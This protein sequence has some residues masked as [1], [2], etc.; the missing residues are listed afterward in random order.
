MTSFYQLQVIETTMPF[1]QLMTPYY[2]D[3]HAAKVGPTSMA[4]GYF[5]IDPSTGAK[6][7]RALRIPLIPPNVLK[8]T[9]S[10]TVTIK[11][12][13]DTTVAQ[14]DD[15]DPIFGISDE[16]RFHGFQTLDVSDFPNYSPCYRMEGDVG[17]LLLENR[18]QGGGPRTNSTHYSSEIMLQMRPMEQW[19]SCHIEQV[20]GLVNTQGYQSTLD[21]TNG[22]FFELYRHNAEE[23]YRIKYFR[24][25]IDL[26]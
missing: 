1:N 2:I 12:A 3:K 9:D 11:S 8:T 24:V 5:V 22:L 4:P 23:V 19:G 18:K 25:D 14:T 16:K 26:D 6:Y 15:H 21:L 20:D 17:Q 7:Q 13:L 10:V